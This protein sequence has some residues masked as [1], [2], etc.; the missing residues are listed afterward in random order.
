MSK[1]YEG[2]VSSLDG[3]TLNLEAFSSTLPRCVE[4]GL[5]KAEDAEFVLNGLKNGFDLGVNHDMLRGRRVH[6]NYKSA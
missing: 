4:A 3:Y 2:G 6:K 1:I 5:V